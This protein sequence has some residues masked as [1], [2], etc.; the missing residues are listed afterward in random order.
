LRPFSG[1]DK[2]TRL[3][4]GNFVLVGIPAYQQRHLESVLNAAARLAYRLRRY[5]T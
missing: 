4:Y 2:T 5:T 1:G 3:D